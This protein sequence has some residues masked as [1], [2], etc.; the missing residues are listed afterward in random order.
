[1][2]NKFQYI[3]NAVSLNVDTLEANYVTTLSIST[4]CNSDQSTSIL[5]ISN[6][7]VDSLKINIKN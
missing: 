5:S 7:N 3:V 2:S 4:L 1:M 6:S